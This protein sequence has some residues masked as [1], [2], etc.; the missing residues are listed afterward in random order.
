MLDSDDSSVHTQLPRANERF[1]TGKS[2]SKPVRRDTILPKR[3]CPDREEFGKENGNGLKQHTN[4]RKLPWISGLQ[5]H[6]SP[7]HVHGATL[8]LESI[9]VS[10]RQI[11]AMIVVISWNQRL[12]FFLIFYETV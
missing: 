7:F 2:N 10:R 4:K 12:S 5:V 1:R 8:S 3:I 11:Y 9:S 6:T